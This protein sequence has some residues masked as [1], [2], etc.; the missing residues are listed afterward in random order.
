ME[1][2]GETV[3]VGSPRIGSRGLDENAGSVFDPRNVLKMEFVGKYYDIIRQFM[4]AERPACPK[5]VA[6]LVDDARV[7]PRPQWPRSV[8][9]EFCAAH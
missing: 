3:E 6:L 9:V 8:R 4:A 7:R 2:L 5:P 1:W